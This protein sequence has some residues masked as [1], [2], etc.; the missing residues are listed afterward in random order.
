MQ[1]LCKTVSLPHG[2]VSCTHLAPKRRCV[3]KVKSVAQESETTSKRDFDPK[4]F[5]RS[6]NKSGRYQRNPTNDAASQTV[7]E[8][9]GVGYSS[10]GLVAQMRVN[11]NEWQQGDIYVQLAEVYG[12]C[13]GVERSVQM[14]Y[15]ARNNWNDNKIYLTNEI[16]H[17][18]SVNQ[19]MREMGIEFVDEEKSSE[20]HVVRDFSPI[21]ENDVVLLPAFGASVHEMK[22]LSEK[23]V[24]IVDTTCPW[25][26]KVWNA[27]DKHARKECTSIIHGKWQ[28]EET[29]ATASFAKRYVIV[30]NIPEA[31][32]LCDYLIN[33]GNKEEF[34]AKFKNAMSEDFDPDT[35]LQRVGLA[36]QTTMLKGETEQ[37]GKMLEKAV[38]MKFG[39]DKINEHFMIMDTICDATQE[40]QDAMYKLTENG[41]KDVDMI[42]VVGGFN[43]SNTSHLQEIAEH[44]NIPSFWIDS[45][46]R[47]NV[48]TNQVLHKTSWGELVETNNWLPEGPIKIG[49]T[50]GAS[51]P[52]R[53][54]EDVLDKVFKI[55]DPSFTG[56]VPKQMQ[57]QDKQWDDHE[58]I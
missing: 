56:I 31:E 50:S 45:A 41:T 24:Q 2:R 29:V 10:T 7:I 18:P 47:I 48:Q 25:V 51:T 40:R 38:L 4:A 15:E 32:Y 33:G 13:W 46:A 44:K 58:E 11:N 6:L 35:M 26:S 20:G 12:Y 19:R 34:L 39:P 8:E 9:H 37:I 30:K 5:R 54:V 1:Q 23:G 28:H 21:K 3:I 55:K 52:D 42:L 22:E 17:N 14:A 49:I 57:L 43:S 53:T 16:I 27:V 36:N